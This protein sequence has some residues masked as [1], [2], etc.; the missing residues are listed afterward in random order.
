MEVFSNDRTITCTRDGDRWECEG[1]TTGSRRHTDRLNV[2]DNPKEVPKEHINSIEIDA[3]YC[4]AIHT[5]R[6]V[7]SCGSK[8]PGR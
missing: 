5:T 3:S 2:G 1:H 7:L 8:R 4:D 6:R